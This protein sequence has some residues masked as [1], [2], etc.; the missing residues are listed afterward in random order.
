MPRRALA[1][2]A[3]LIGLSIAAQAHAGWVRTWAASTR[4]MSARSSR[5]AGYCLSTLGS[6]PGMMWS[7]E[8][9]SL[10]RVFSP[11]M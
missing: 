2:V 1:L 5:M 7:G 4:T 9:A 6:W 3:G 8:L 11:S 10:R